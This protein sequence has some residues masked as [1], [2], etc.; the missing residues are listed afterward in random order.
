MMPRLDEIVDTS[1]MQRT[2]AGVMRFEL[3]PFMEWL[4]EMRTERP[5]SFAV[6]SPAVKLA[7]GHY[8]AGKR[9]AE[10]LRAVEG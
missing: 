5:K 4:S 6:L 9:R 3:N 1:R 7:F 10:L 2:A 8:E